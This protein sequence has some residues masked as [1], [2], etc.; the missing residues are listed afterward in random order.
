MGIFTRFADI[1]NSNLNAML[2]R[3]EDPEKMLKLIIQEME[4]TLVEVRSSSVKPIAEKK[5]L[6]RHMAETLRHINRWNEKAELAISKGRDDLAKAALIEKQ[7]LKDAY[8]NQEQ[9]LAHL[10]VAMAQLNEDITRLQE[11]LAEAKSRKEAMKLRQKTVTTRLKVK[12][13]LDSN[14]I[15]EA[16][17]KFEQF[18]QKMD[19]LEAEVESYDLGKG[20]S[21]SDQIDQLVVDEKIEAELEAMRSKLK[22]AS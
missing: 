17:S 1:V 15:D 5:E 7:A 11:K 12:Q 9:E 20:T 21:L 18:E 16:F 14:S 6:T 19:R 22:K 10:E 8:D 3:A 4:Q 2:D 13:Q